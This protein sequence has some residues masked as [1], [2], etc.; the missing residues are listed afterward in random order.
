MLY[1]VDMLGP[2]NVN[3]FVRKEIGQKYSC[4]FH[5]MILSRK[6]QLD[7]YVLL[8]RVE[9]VEFSDKL[10]YSDDMTPQFV[11][12]SKSDRDDACILN[13]NYLFLINTLLIYLVLHFL[14]VYELSRENKGMTKK[15]KII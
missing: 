1:M 6:K 2:E 13:L 4:T 12:Q 3:D 15:C 5:K 9:T 11:N 14:F 8:Q 7:L 10:I